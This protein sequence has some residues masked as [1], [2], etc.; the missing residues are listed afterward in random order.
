MGVIRDRAAKWLGLEKRNSADATARLLQIQA[1]SLSTTQLD[2]KGL[3]YVE[4]ALRVIESAFTMAEIQPAVMSPVTLATAVRR[5]ALT[6]EAPHIIE[7]GDG[8][9]MLT[10]VVIEDVTKSG[11]YKI[12]GRRASVDPAD[13]I[14]FAWTRDGMRGRSILSESLA[15][16]GGASSVSLAVQIEAALG[17]EARKP[18]GDIIPIAEGSESSEVQIHSTAIEKLRGRTYLAESQRQEAMSGPAVGGDWKPRPLRPEPA[19]HLVKL[20]EEASADIVSALGVPPGL[21]RAGE[22]EN[23]EDARQFLVGC[24]RPTARRIEA[25]MADKMMAAVK[26]S[27]PEYRAADDRSKG[28]YLKALVDSG[29]ELDRALK[30]AGIEG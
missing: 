2:V 18:V 8:G 13:I 22:R 19:E 16:Y 30:V 6:G 11:R 17:D 15:Y 21:V 12:E 14:L 3:S 4:A 29:M 23:R 1:A 10:P 20:R 28:Q 7:A 24:L 9:A 25:E 27:F 5:S 26:I